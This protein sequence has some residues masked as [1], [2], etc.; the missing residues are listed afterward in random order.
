MVI[1]THEIQFAGEVS[2][3]VIF[4]DQGKIVEQGAPGQI[5]GNAAA[6]P[7]T[8]EFLKQLAGSLSKTRR[9]PMN[10]WAVMVDRFPYFMSLLLRAR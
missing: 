10:F 3:R 4:M 7:R 1:V 6:K 8:R 9:G 2:D 5:L